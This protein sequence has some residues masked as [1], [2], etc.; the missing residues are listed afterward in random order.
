M[1]RER[2]SA[3]A[4]DGPDAVAYSQRGH[5]RRVPV[6]W[7]VERGRSVE[8]GLRVC[9]Q[10]CA[11]SR[12]VSMGMLC[13]GGNTAHWRHVAQFRCEDCSGIHAQVTSPLQGGKK[14]TSSRPG[15]ARVR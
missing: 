2:A 10:N 15:E 13:M 5:P 9:M 3:E 1:V 4:I 11:G 8:G 14:A 6:E 7:L 12:G